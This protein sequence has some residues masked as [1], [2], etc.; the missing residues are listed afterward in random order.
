MK[1]VEPNA[2][3]PHHGLPAE[4][5]TINVVMAAPEGVGGEPTI[6][7]LRE[8]PNGWWQVEERHGGP[9]GSVTTWPVLHH[10]I[11][12]VRAVLFARSHFSARGKPM[13]NGE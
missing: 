3:V 6:F 1:S 5:R 11:T 9:A 4:R 2:G 13:T 8:Q 7:T 10:S 12:Q